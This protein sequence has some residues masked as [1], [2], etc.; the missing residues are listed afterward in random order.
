MIRSW[1]WLITGIGLIF[2]AFFSYQ[3][4]QV[5][6]GNLLV[7]PI[8]EKPQQPLVIQLSAEAKRGETLFKN[9]CATCHKVNRPLTGPPL[10]NMIT[11]YTTDEDKAWMYRWVKNA[12]GMISSGDERAIELFK[13]Y[14]MIAMQS[15]PNLS[16]QDIGGIMA[17]VSETMD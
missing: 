3:I 1:I 6:V 9:N 4:S 12:P 16:D 7:N 2:W 11:N 10:A 13:R 14:N 17:Y 15:F 8:M 5:E